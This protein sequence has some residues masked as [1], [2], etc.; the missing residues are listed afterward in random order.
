MPSATDGEGVLLPQ[1]NV[2]AGLS[3]L[4]HNARPSGSCEL[5]N[6]YRVPY[7]HPTKPG[8]VG[9]AP[10]RSENTHSVFERSRAEP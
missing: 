5:P 4:N 10:C 6:T 1:G 8:V 7:S 3:R 2:L 9:E